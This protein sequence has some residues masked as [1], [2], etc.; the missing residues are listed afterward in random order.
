ME[1]AVSE[2]VYAG[3]AMSRRLFYQYGVQLARQPVWPR[4]PG[5]RAKESSAGWERGADRSHPDLVEEPIE[6]LTV[7]GVRMILPKHAGHRGAFRD[8]HLL[9]RDHKALWM[10]EN[11][12]SGLDPQ[13]LHAARRSGSPLPRT[14][15]KYINEALY[16]FGVKTRR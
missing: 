5:A 16:R 8:E 3:N 15:S 4:R 12:V 7:D 14:W 6:E 10:A 9:P 13:H 11:V 1:H 2:N